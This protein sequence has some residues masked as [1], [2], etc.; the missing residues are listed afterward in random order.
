LTEDF[1]NPENRSERALYASLRLP[2]S[3]HEPKPG[4]VPLVDY[5]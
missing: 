1:A 5:H 4:R 2:W 3:I